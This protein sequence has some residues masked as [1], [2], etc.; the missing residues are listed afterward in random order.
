MG[1]AALNTDVGELGKAIEYFSQA[2]DVVVEFGNKTSEAVILG[3]LGAAHLMNGVNETAKKYFIR[4]LEINKQL[5]SRTTRASNLINLGIV[6]SNDGDFEQALVYQNEAVELSRAAGDRRIESIALENDA[7]TMLKEHLASNDEPESVG[8]GSESLKKASSLFK[9]SSE[10][11]SE[12]GIP[13]FIDAV[14]GQARC[15]EMIGNLELAKELA[16][17]VVDHL[18]GSEKQSNEAHGDPEDLAHIRRILGVT[19][20]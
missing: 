15:E 11:A 20:I 9:S 16:Q 8:A 4:A 10:L 17:K 2:L 18:S 7:S 19:K 5:G 3:N 12:I 1:L 6:F 14:V 13:I